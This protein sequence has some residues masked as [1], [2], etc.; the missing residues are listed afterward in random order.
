MTEDFLGNSMMFTRFSSCSLW[1]FFECNPFYFWI[2]WNGFDWVLTPVVL[3]TLFSQFEYLI[4]TIMFILSSRQ[5]IGDAALASYVLKNKDP[6]RVDTFAVCF[7][8]GVG[9]MVGI[10][11]SSSVSGMKRCID[12]YKRMISDGKE[13]HRFLKWNREERFYFPDL[14][15]NVCGFRIKITMNKGVERI[16]IINHSLKR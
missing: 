10:T 4:N 14:M 5:V 13:G 15:S 6:A 3:F 1:F 9:A 7:C 8:W 11:A 12:V 16:V 2:S